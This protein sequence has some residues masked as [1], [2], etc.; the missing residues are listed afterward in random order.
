MIKRLSFTPL[1]KAGEP[2]KDIIA[3]ENEE[4]EYL[5]NLEKLRVGAWMSWCLTLRVGCY[6]SAGCQ[7]EVREKTRE[8]NAKLSKKTSP[9]IECTN[10]SPAKGQANAGKGEGE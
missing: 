4:G 7:D 10:N 2:F 9:N 6:L 1:I 5:G 3:I 8:L